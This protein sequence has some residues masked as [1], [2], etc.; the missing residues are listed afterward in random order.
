MSETPTPPTPVEPAAVVTPPAE[1]T[2]AAGWEARYR[3]EVTDRIKE[4]NLYKPAQRLLADLDDGSREELIRLAEMAR[5]QDGDGIVAWAEG[6]I[7][8]ISGKDIAQLVADR[9]KA[10]G[11]GQAP[12]PETP[13]SGTPAPEPGMTPTQ[14]ADMVRKEMADAAALEAGRVRVR[15]EL[16]KGGYTENSPQGQTIINYAWAN[17]A[18]VPTAIAWYENETAT[19]ALDR[20]RAAAGATGQVPSPAPAGAPV[21]AIPNNASPR[22]LAIARLNADQSGTAR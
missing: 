10:A 1:P 17:K 7:A 12:T 16:A 13:P 2:D 18:D 21:G 14:V 6:T 22:E 3:T 11:L 19:S 20:A 15:D 8:A 9:Q 5:N 4:R